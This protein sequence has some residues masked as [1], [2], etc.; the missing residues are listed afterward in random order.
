M[1]HESKYGVIEYR[2]PNIPEAI[3]LMGLMG[4]NSEVMKNQEEM[5]QNEL[6]YVSRI[7]K[8]MGMFVTKVDITIDKKKINKYGDLLDSF[9]MMEDLS[10]ISGQVLEGLSA[11]EEK[12]N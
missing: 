3:E 1:I 12:K 8:H 5:K 11:S 2:K 7:I 6:L 10:T 9:C 4:L